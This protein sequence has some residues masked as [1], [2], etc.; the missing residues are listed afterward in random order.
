ML[1]KDDELLIIG[2]INEEKIEGN[3]LLKD[4]KFVFFDLIQVS[5]MF[6]TFTDILEKQKDIVITNEWVEKAEMPY[7]EVFRILK[8]PEYLRDV[9]RVSL[10]SFANGG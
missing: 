2:L 1:Q 7:Q 3:V 10:F 8:S 9:P 5:P 6:K 4:V